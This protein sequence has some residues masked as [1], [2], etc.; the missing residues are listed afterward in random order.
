M[1]Q[2]TEEARKAYRDMIAAFEEEAEGR[3]RETELNIVTTEH[4]KSFLS[5]TDK[6]ASSEL[7]DVP[8]YSEYL[9]T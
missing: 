6:T 4:E 1:V 9:R 7:E 5:D 2:L 3:L 8:N